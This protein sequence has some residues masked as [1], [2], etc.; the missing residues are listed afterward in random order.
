MAMLNEL[1]SQI[2]ADGV[3]EDGE[4]EL[5]RKQLYADG[6]IEK[7][8][9]EFLVMLRNEAKSVAPSFEPFFFQALKDYLLADGVI[10]AGEAAFLR[11]ALYADGKIDDG[12][13]MFLKELKALAK[14]VSPEFQEL[15]DECVK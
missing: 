15:Y 12:E 10:D 14:S 2:L 8:E 7:D 1:K 5:L 4:V 9:A 6:V 13:K 11:R 3:I